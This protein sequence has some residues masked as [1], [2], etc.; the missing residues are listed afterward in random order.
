M[1][2]NATTLEEVNDM[3]SR[4]STLSDELAK[5]KNKMRSLY[6][7]MPFVIA[8][9]V[10]ASLRAA[11]EQQEQLGVKSVNN[12]LFLDAISKGFKSKVTADLSDVFENLNTSVDFNVVIENSF[13]CV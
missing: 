10:Y 4:K 8:E 7:V 6:D 2:G 5:L 3:L 13:F 11:V 9:S 12:K 1:E